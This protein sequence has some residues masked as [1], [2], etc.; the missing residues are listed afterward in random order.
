MESRVGVGEGA[1]RAHLFAE[2]GPDETAS[3]RSEPHRPEDRREVRER[4]ASGA[5]V[6]ALASEGSA[7]PATVQVSAA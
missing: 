4:R 1:P 5:Q 3:P 6:A 2:P 7:S